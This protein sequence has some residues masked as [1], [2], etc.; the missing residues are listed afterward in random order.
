MAGPSI[1]VGADSQLA[2]TM[3]EMLREVPPLPTECCIFKVPESLR[4]GNEEAYTPIVISIGPL[5]HE[6]KKLQPFEAHKKRYLSSFLQ[7]NSDISL[8]DCVKLLRGLEERAH[9]FYFED[10]FSVAIAVTTNFLE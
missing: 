2:T 4:S 6:E 1:Q 8:E 7:R 3:V 5:H 10:Q 9:N